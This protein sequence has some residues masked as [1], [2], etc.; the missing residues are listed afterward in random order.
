MYE[1]VK[2]GRDWETTCK[3][4]NRSASHSSRTKIFSKKKAAYRQLLDILEAE[5]LCDKYWNLCLIGPLGD[6]LL[7][8]YKEES[9]NDETVEPEKKYDFI[10]VKSISRFGRN[11]LE[12]QEYAH[13]LKGL[14]VEVRFEREGFSTFDAKSEMIFNFLTAIAEEES[15][16]ISEN[17]RVTYHRLAEMG[18]RHIGNNRVLGYDEIDG[19]LVPNEQAWIPALIFTEYAKGTAICEIVKLLKAKNAKRIRN[20]SEKSLSA[21]TFCSARNS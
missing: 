7:K 10:L 19:E 14:G 8:F 4:G 18:V 20:R 2:V 1:T 17:V 13:L 11:S 5:G 3:V 9:K 16:S 12:A 6:E 21:T 15:K